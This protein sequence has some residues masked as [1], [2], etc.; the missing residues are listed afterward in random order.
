MINEFQEVFLKDLSRVSPKKEI[1]IEIDL[2]LNT[3]TILIP[4][5]RM[6]LF[7]LKKLKEKLKYLLD[8]CFIRPNISSWVALVL[9]VQT[10]I[11]F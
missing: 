6:A 5:Y 2:L 8:K 10:K 7:E 3:H 1:D 4:P 9:L 11:I